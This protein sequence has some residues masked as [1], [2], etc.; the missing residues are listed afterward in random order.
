[1]IDPDTQG[2]A[3]FTAAGDQFAESVHVIPPVA[4]IDSHLI[5]RCGRFE[6]DGRIEM[7]VGHQRNGP[8]SLRGEFLFDRCQIAS[9]TPT[10]GGETYDFAAGPDDPD[11]LSGRSGGVIGVGI[12]HR[13]ESDGV[14]PT[15]SHGTY[16]DLDRMP[17][18]ILRK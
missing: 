8:E 15:E 5:G 16:P 7:D 4:G 3:A 12:G 11:D 10:L 6:C 2:H 13:L 17:A 14:F 9:F 1:M 18:R